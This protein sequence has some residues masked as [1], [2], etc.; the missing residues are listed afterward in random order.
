[1]VAVKKHMIVSGLDVGTTKVCCL[2]GEIGN[3][4]NLE[5][6]GKGIAPS[7]GVKKGV[8]VDIAETVKSI[9]LAAQEAE[10][11][12][13]F[14]LH[15]VFVGV[16]GEHISSIN[17]HGVITLAHEPK[18]VVEDDVR[19]AVEAAKVV[20]LPAEREVIHVIPRGF[21]LDGQNG[22]KNPVGMLGMRLEVNTHIVTGMGT[23]LHNLTKCVETAGLEIEE[24]G[25]VLEP[26]ASSLSVLNEAEK[27]LG[28]LLIDIGGGTTDLAVFRNRHIFHSSVIPVGGNHVTYDLAVAFR[29]S[30]EEAERVKV[31]YGSAVPSQISEEDKI[32]V[33]TLSGMKESISRRQVAET[34]APRME[35]L[36]ALIKREI[37]QLPK[38]SSLAGVTITG[39]TSLLP[40]ISDVAAEILKFPVRVGYPQPSTGTLNDAIHNPAYSTGVGL[41]IYGAKSL[42]NRRLYRRRETFLAKAF[43]SLFR[44]FF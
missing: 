7:H 28:I 27:E 19:R 32:E 3:D 14:K 10:R 18:E 1:M 16:T 15:S 4:G 20:S 39:G 36:F 30:P 24:N 29:L 23:F 42:Q 26:L 25:L 35:E 8:V 9:Q 5:I 31:S 21:T 11:G 34:I 40:G 44:E 38:D 33:T 17:S 41:V 12:A 43:R 2:I 13:G 6:I 22:V 37:E